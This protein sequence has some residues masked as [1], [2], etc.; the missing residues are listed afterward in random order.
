MSL[1]YTTQILYW[2]E[3]TYTNL[4]LN[5]IVEKVNW[6]NLHFYNISEFIDKY[7]PLMLFRENYLFWKMEPEIWHLYIF[8]LKNKNNN[9]TT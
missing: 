6:C 1:F 2:M 4:G 7:L 9:N 3:T 8:I 5:Q